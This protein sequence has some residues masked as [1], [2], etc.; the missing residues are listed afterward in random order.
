MR[1]PLSPLPG[2]FLPT[3]MAESLSI[4]LAA[5]PLEPKMSAAVSMY[6]AFAKPMS[7]NFCTKAPM[8]PYICRFILSCS[9]NT[10]PF[11]RTRRL[12]SSTC[13]SAPMML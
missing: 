4:I 5:R 8:S 12:S 11:F 10:P 13:L 1:K 3:I 2:H 6:T 9:T 7:G